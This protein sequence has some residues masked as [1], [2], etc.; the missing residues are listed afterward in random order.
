MKRIYGE[1][2]QQTLLLADGKEKI[3]EEKEVKGEKEDDAAG[4][5][6]KRDSAIKS[7][8]SSDIIVNYL[9]FP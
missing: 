3:K 5:F 1:E 8:K 9:K 2:A 6:R 7:T 4:G